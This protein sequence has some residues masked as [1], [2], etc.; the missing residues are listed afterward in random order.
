LATAAPE[1]A[2]AYPGRT[3]LLALSLKANW[4]FWLFVQVEQAATLISSLSF[5]PRALKRA[6]EF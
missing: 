2:T 6:A 1:D 3:K 4:P 5:S